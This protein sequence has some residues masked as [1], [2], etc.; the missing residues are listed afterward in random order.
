MAD[1]LDLLGAVVAYVIF[2]SSIAT[3]SLRMVAGVGPG[4][5]AGVPLLLM[6]LPLGYLL[7][8][9]PEAGRPFLYYLQVGLMISFI[10]VLFV[11]DYWFHI[12]FRDT[13]WMV[14]AFVMLYFGALGG[15]IG[16]ASLAGRAWTV[17][18][19]SLFFVTAVLAFV[20]RAV[21]GL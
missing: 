1:R 21:T 13:R 18:A 7:V 10:I 8:K 5:W 9:A 17:G 2:V 14:I 15:M 16:V 12:E 3:F 4:H 19:V 20:Q 11:V 6:A